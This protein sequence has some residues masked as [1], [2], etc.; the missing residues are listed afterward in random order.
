MTNT[1]EVIARLSNRELLEAIPPAV[2]RERRATAEL[3]A[4]LAEMDARKLYLGEGYSSLFSYCTGALHLSEPAAFSRITAARATRRFPVLLTQ[5]ASGDITL[6]TITLLAGHLTDDNLDALLQAT[7]HQSKRDVERI[8]AS[9]QP[10]PHVPPSVRRLPDLAKTPS[11]QARAHGGTAPSIGNSAGP[12]SPSSRTFAPAGSLP[13]RPARRRRDYVAPISAERYLVR[14]TID[15]KTYRKLG[16]AR[17]LLRH[18]IPNGDPAAI[19]DRALTVLVEQLEKAKISLTRRPRRSAARS[20]RSRRVPA[21][22]RRAVWQR[23]QGRCAFVGTLGRCPETG[24]LEFHHVVPY[25]A[26]GT[27]TTDNLQLRCRAHNAYEATNYFGTGSET[28]SAVGQSL[29]T[30]ANSS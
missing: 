24:F 15:G 1:A 23:D 20:S 5:L 22:V 13:R 26:G 28:R 30:I 18:V 12:V 29:P 25:A 17:D 21:A 27:T 2:A 9:L 19:L 7:R 4:L 14:V 8:V 3:I 10:H 11:H 6:T 16:R